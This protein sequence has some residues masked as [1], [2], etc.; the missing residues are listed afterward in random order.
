[1]IWKPDST[2]SAIPA[3]RGSSLRGSDLGRKTGLLGRSRTQAFCVLRP[4][5]KCFYSKALRHFFPGLGRL[6]RKFP[7]HLI[8]A[9]DQWL[10]ARF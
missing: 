8:V 6:G 3:I 9:S 1:M 10:V 4:K 2:I 7:E 5:V